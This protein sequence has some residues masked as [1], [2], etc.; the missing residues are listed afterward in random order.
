MKRETVIFAAC[1]V[2]A[3]LGLVVK[4]ID[5]KNQIRNPVVVAIIGYD[6]ASK[7]LHLI[8]SDGTTK[9]ESELIGE[10]K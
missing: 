7:E 10:G 3:V 4:A 8:M 9:W 6:E 1:L 2:V 5:L